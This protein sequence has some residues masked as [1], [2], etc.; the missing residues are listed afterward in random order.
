MRRGRATHGLT[1]TW[2]G[3]GDESSVIHRAA[4]DRSPDPGT[5]LVSRVSKQSTISK[6]G[7]HLINSCGGVKLKSDLNFF[8]SASVFFPLLAPE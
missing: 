4:A 8:Q 7:R 1:E 6:E 5:S 2:G 3:P